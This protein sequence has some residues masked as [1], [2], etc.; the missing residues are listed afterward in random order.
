VPRTA[1]CYSAGFRALPRY[2]AAALR[3][4][5]TKQR[6]KKTGDRVRGEYSACEGIADTAAATSG[7]LNK[8]NFACLRRL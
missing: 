3:R 4:A 5:K 6:V 7:R 8:G 2:Y 1:V